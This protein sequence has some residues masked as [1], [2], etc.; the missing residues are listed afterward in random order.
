MK[1]MGKKGSLAIVFLL[2]IALLP[3]FGYRM[4]EAKTK[5]NA[6]SVVFTQD[7]GK[8]LDLFVG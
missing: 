1:K 7:I 2:V 6:K 8:A 3:V 4:T 5:V